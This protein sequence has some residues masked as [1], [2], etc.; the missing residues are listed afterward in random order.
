MPIAEKAFLLGLLPA[1]IAVVIFCHNV[2]NATIIIVISEDAQNSLIKET[3]VLTHLP[4]DHLLTRT[5]V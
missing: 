3:H 5:K 2:E 4:A 1:R